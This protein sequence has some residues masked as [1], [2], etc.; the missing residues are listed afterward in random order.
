LAIAELDRFL[1][2]AQEMSF[3]NVQKARAGT[4]SFAS[5][6]NRLLE[7]GVMVSSLADGGST[8]KK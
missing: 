1:S 7:I 3:D 2:T 5:G 4:L 8:E 6:I